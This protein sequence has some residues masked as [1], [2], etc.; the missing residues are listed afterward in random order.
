MPGETR[1][2]VIAS[3]LA[4]TTSLVVLASVKLEGIREWADTYLEPVVLVFDVVM[5]ILY[6]TTGLVGAP[7][8]PAGNDAFTLT[9]KWR[10]R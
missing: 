8:L 6:L 3:T 4:I 5:A 2:S 9:D 1:P 10:T 7:Q